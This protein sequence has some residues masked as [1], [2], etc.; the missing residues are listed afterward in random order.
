MPK[1]S[2]DE[3]VVSAVEKISPSVVNISTVRLLRDYFFNVH[4]ISGI[5]SGA[6]I[7]SKGYIVTNHHVIAGS[8]R[9]DVT[10]ADGRKFSGKLI[11]ADASSD[12][13]IVKV[14]EE[15]LPSAEL[16]DSD[17]LRVGQFVIAIGNPFAL[18]GGPTVTTGVVS[19]LNRN[20]QV[21][22]HVYESLIQTDAAIN[23]GNSGGPLMD[24]N[25]RVIGIST[26]MIPFAQGIGFAIPINS[27]KKIVDELISYGRVIRPW[28]GLI[29][30]SITDEIAS[31]YELPVKAG[32][33]VARIIYGSP[34]H[35]VGISEGDLI[36]KING[37]SIKTIQDLQKSIQK[38]EV[39]DKV[40]VEL[41]RGYQ[42]GVVEVT[43][44][45][46]PQV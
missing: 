10:L 15:G 20:I 11:G 3:W 30:M 25:G 12:I 13:A 21:E 28:L 31:Y 43:L 26:A 1:E 41:I 34:A 46:V 32:V 5:G 29:G 18:V 16:G 4:P 45:E 27:V 39:G 17:R 14:D 8:D 24:S 19:A 38:K 22:N 35:R 7:N 42:R 2:P 37:T 23:P 6:I 40:E 9:I 36:V 44:A 33:I